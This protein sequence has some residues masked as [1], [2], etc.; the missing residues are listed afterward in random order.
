MTSMTSA[1]LARTSLLVE[2]ADHDVFALSDDRLGRTN[3][4]QHEIH[5]GDSSLIRQQFRRVYPQKRQEM[6]R[7]S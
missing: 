3:I 1:W 7:Q 5:T 6:R 4:L 2:Y